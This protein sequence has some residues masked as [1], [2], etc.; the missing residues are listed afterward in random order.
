EHHH[1]HH[2]HDADEVFVSWGVETPRKFTE[3][4]IR[5]ILSA[6]DGGKYGQ[7]IRAKGFVDAADGESW[8]HFDLVPGEH[9]LRRGAAG[10]TGR[11]CVIG[12]GLQENALKELFKVG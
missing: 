1:H 11:L 6:L 5:S 12:S 8:I 2:G 4:E 3:A 7:V 9:E 10:A